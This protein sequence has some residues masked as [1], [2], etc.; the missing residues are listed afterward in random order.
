MTWRAQTDFET[1]KRRAAGRRHYNAWRHFLA[2]YRRKQV[3]ELLFQKGKGL[4]TRG[5]QTEIAQVLHVHRSTIHRDIKALLT[6]GGPGC[7]CPLFGTLLLR[8]EATDNSDP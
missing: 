7:P 6:A 1:V 4:F 3:S 2:L 8:Q 5:V